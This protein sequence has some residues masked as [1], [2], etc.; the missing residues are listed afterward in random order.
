MINKKIIEQNLDTWSKSPFD[1][2]ISRVLK[3]KD[4]N[5]DF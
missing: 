2:T 4:T 3:L 5:N 1:K